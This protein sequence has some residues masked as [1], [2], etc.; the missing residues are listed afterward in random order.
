MAALPSFSITRP[1]SGRKLR[2]G[3]IGCGARMR[4]LILNAMQEEIVA[5]AD[6]DPSVF[7]K[8]FE[9]LKGYGQEETVRKIRTFP[10]YREM[11]D[12][13]SGELDAVIVATTNLHHAPASI[14]IGRAHV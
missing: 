3:L 9:I 14:K 1:I 8:L 6:P 7:E 12:K 10:C 13:M 5:M 4:S 11:L 2:V